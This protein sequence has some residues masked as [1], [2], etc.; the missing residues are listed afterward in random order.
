MKGFYSYE[1]KEFAEQEYKHAL[2][3]ASKLDDHI[4]SKWADNIISNGFSVGVVPSILSRPPIMI[5]IFF[6]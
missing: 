5:L 1:N 2:I 6:S 4:F 3:V